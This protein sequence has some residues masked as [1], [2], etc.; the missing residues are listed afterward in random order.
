MI[1]TTLK[2]RK[3]LP[4]EHSTGGMLKI[5]GKRLGIFG[6]VVILNFILLGA[7]AIVLRFP[8]IHI[9]LIVGLILFILFYKI[10]TKTLYEKRRREEFEKRDKELLERFDQ[11]IE[12]FKRG[13]TEEHE[14]RVLEQLKEELKKKSI[15]VI[16]SINK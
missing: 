2:N 3:M 5:Y 9:L 12:Q 1:T 6:G 7:I 16:S 13:I 14:K 10:R 11:L 8:S 15:T 4:L